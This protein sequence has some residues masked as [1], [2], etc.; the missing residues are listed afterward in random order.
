VVRI[1][2]AK[3]GVFESNAAEVINEINSFIGSLKD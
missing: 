2:H 3:H 1:A